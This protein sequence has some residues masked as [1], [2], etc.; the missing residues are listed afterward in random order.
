MASGK[1][2][3]ITSVADISAALIDKYGE[4]DVGVNPNG[5]TVH[6]S[7]TTVIIFSCLAISDKVIHMTNYT[8]GYL[9]YGDT[10]D[11]TTG[12]TNP[13][14]FAGNNFSGVPTDRILILTDN[15]AVFNWYRGVDTTPLNAR[16]GVI[17]KLSNGK[18][19]CIGSY[20][21]I[22]YFAGTN[23]YITD[24]NVECMIVT[25]KG[26]MMSGAGEIYKTKVYISSALYGAQLNTDGSLAYMLDVD[27]AYYQTVNP[28]ITSTYVLTSYRGY[29][30]NTN[31]EFANS[32]LVELETT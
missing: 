25:P 5:V 27:V 9:S 10:F 32:L 22:N 17:G 13:I 7:T 14:V 11:G 31:Q 4:Y 29:V 20:Q 21:N 2:Y 3:T 26:F 23:G 12:I 15:T 16:M 1:V 18:Y 24:N 28:I 19:L 8:Y 30:K 6:Y